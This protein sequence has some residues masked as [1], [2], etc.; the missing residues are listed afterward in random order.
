MVFAELQYPEHYSDVHDDLLA[1]IC[2]HFSNVESGHQGD[3]YIWIRD[4]DEKVAIDTF[5]SMTHQVKSPR[6]GQHVQRVIEALQLRFK[7]KV[8]ENPELEGNEPAS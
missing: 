6:P 5:S 8:Y 7:V 4:G 2:K 1:F 3:S